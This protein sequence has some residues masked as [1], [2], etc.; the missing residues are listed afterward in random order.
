M[1]GTR[2]A[3]PSGR[4]NRSVK[5]SYRVLSA[6]LLPASL[7]AAFATFKNGG[8]IESAGAGVLLA[9]T[10]LLSVWTFR[11]NKERL[12][13]LTTTALIGLVWAGILFLAG[14]VAGEGLSASVGYAGGGALLVCAWG[15]VILP[16]RG[17][18]RV[19]R[20]VWRRARNRRAGG[21]AAP[22]ANSAMRRNSVRD[23]AKAKAQKKRKAQR[24]ARARGRR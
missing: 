6:V 19:G 11:K 5:L 9:V 13:V 15:I 8:F 22:A 4:T 20:S 10:L 2:D 17:F 3:K 1:N 21:S 23:S 12:G 18:W 16:G 24:Q 14:I 7:A